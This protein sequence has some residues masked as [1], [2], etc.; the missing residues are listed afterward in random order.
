MTSPNKSGGEPD[1]SYC[2]HEKKDT[3][4]LAIEVALTSGGLSKRAFYASLGVPELWIWRNNTLEV[5]LLNNKQDDYNLSDKSQQLDGINLGDV[6]ECA[7]M[8]FASDA[9][10]EFKQRLKTA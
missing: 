2:F 4:D 7:L 8:D 3:P 10:I 5:H 1:E 9:V 6:Q